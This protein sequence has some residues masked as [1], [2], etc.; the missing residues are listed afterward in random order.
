MRRSPVKP[1]VGLLECKE[2]CDFRCLT[3]REFVVK[4]WSVNDGD[5]ET[6]SIDEMCSSISGDRDEGNRL[7]QWAEVCV[8]FGPTSRLVGVN[9]Y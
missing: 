2:R 4:F 8:A 9:S 1:D 5:F 3:T 7:G 6:Q